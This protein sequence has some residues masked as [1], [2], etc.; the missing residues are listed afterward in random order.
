MAAAGCYP[1]GTDPFLDYAILGDALVIADEA[2]AKLYKTRWERLKAATPP[3]GLELAPK[4]FHYVSPQELK[5]TR[6]EESFQRH[7]RQQRNGLYFT[8]AIQVPVL[9]LRKWNLH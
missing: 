7:T 8:N 5:K 6:P 1:N 9:H 2:V 3:L 4:V